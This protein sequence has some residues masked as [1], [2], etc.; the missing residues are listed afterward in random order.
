MSS[1]PPNP[2]DKSAGESS[3]LLILAEQSTQ[4]FPPDNWTTIVCR[5]S[6]FD[7]ELLEMELPSASSITM[8]VSASNDM[9]F[10][11]YLDRVPIGIRQLG[12]N[13]LSAAVGT[14]LQQ[15]DDEPETTYNM[16][17]SSGDLGLALTK[18]VLFD[19][20]NAS[21]WA[22]FA[23]VDDDSLRGELRIRARN[24]SE[25]TKQLPAAAG[26]SQFAA[27]L[28]DDAAATFHLCVRFPEEAPAALLATGTWLQD[29]I[30]PIMQ[31]VFDLGG[32]Q[33]ASL[34]VQ[35]D[36]SG[37]LLQAAIGEAL[38]NHMLARMI[39]SQESMMERQQE[40]QAKTL[41]AQKALEAAGRKTQTP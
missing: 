36:E 11:A 1:L 25:L 31:Q 8:S 19:I 34:T 10:D 27:I 35:A 7:P 12:W 26:S 3:Q 28:N 22:R 4:L 20:D 2:K 5:T 30:T 41:E 33:Q 14:Q 18:A 40:S 15:R 32:S 21:G 23:S 38:A 17:R 6:L 9:G 37:V 13:M 29:A 39:D 16:R 24:N